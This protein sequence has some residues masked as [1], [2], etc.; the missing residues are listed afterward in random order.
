MQFF[1]DSPRLPLE[2]G[3]GLALLVLLVYLAALD[4]EN[5]GHFGEPT[6]MKIRELRLPN[7]LW[8]LAMCAV[9]M[10]KPTCAWYA[11]ARVLVYGMAVAQEMQY[12]R[13]PSMMVPWLAVE[14]M[15]PSPV[16]TLFRW[17]ARS[18][19]HEDAWMVAGV[20]YM[21][22][23]VAKDPIVGMTCAGIMVILAV[24]GWVLAWLRKRGSR[25]GHWIMNGKRTRKAK[26]GERH[27]GIIE[28]LV[29]LGVLAFIGMSAGNGVLSCY[30]V[31]TGIHPRKA[32]LEVDEYHHDPTLNIDH[33]SPERHSGWMPGVIEKKNV[34]VRKGEVL[35]LRLRLIGP[36]SLHCGW[37][38]YDNGNIRTKSHVV[39]NSTV[40]LGDEEKGLVQDDSVKDSATF[41]DTVEAMTEVDEGDTLFVLEAKATW[42]GGSYVGR[43]RKAKVMAVEGDQFYMQTE[44]TKHGDSGWPIF[45]KDNEGFQLVGNS[46]RINTFGRHSNQIEIVHQPEERGVVV[47]QSGHYQMIH[48]H[49]GSGKTR[50]RIPEIVR[51]STGRVY[52]LSPTTVAAKEA[53]DALNDLGI[54]NSLETTGG[55]ANNSRVKVMCHATYVKR[56]YHRGSSFM[57]SETATYIMDEYHARQGETWALAKWLKYKSTGKSRVYLMSATGPGHIMD[58]TN[59]DVDQILCK[60]ENQMLSHLIGGTTKDL[61]IVPGNVP[62]RA[63]KLRQK[64]AAAGDTREVIEMER[65]QRQNL[66]ACRRAERCVIVATNIVEMGANL[67]VENA[68]LTNQMYVPVQDEFGNVTLANRVPPVASMVQQKGRVG[69]RKPGKCYIVCRDQVEE[70]PTFFYKDESL[71]ED[72]AVYMKAMPASVGQYNVYG[73]DD[74]DEQEINERNQDYPTGAPLM[75]IVGSELPPRA[76]RECYESGATVYDLRAWKK[77]QVERVEERIKQPKTMPSAGIIV[78]VGF[79]WLL[80]GADAAVTIRDE[81][82]D[83]DIVDAVKR[84]GKVFGGLKDEIEDE[85]AE[86][87]SLFELPENVVV[88]IGLM[89]MITV[90]LIAVCY[91]SDRIMRM[92]SALNDWLTTYG[93]MFAILTAP[94]MAPETLSEMT[95]LQ[96][97]YVLIVT[98]PMAMLG[99]KKLFA[100]QHSNWHW[101]WMTLV[102][103]CIFTMS[104]GQF[105]V[106]MIRS[107]P[108]ARFYP[109]VREAAFAEIT[110]HSSVGFGLGTRVMLESLGRKKR[111]EGQHA[112]DKP[113]VRENERSWLGV[114]VSILATVEAVAHGLSLVL[115]GATL[116]RTMMR[117]TTQVVMATGGLVTVIG[118]VLGILVGIYVSRGRKYLGVQDVLATAGKVEERSLETNV[119]GAVAY[120]LD[121]VFLTGRWMMG[122]DIGTNIIG[123]AVVAAMMTGKLPAKLCHY[124]GGL[125]TQGVLENV[126]IPI[127]P[128]VVLVLMGPGLAATNPR[129]QGAIGSSG[130]FSKGWVAVKNIMNRMN[131]EEFAKFKFRGTVVVERPREICSK[132][133]YKTMYLRMSGGFRPFGHVIEDGGGKGGSTQE[134]VRQ[135]N[136]EKVTTLCFEK[137]GHMEHRLHEKR[138]EGYEKSHLVHGD[139]HVIGPAMEGDCYFNDIGESKPTIEE[140]TKYSRRHMEGVRTRLSK[141]RFK[142]ICVKELA[143]W[144]TERVAAFCKDFGLGWMTTPYTRNSSTEV[145]L[146]T[147][148]KD[149][150]TIDQRSREIL[151]RMGKYEPV[152]RIRGMTIPEEP[153]DHEY[154]QPDPVKDADGWDLPEPDY[155]DSKIT[156]GMK[157]GEIKLP[158]HRYRSVREV[159]YVENVGDTTSGTPMNQVIGRLIRL[160]KAAGCLGFWSLTD[161]SARAVFGVFNRKVDTP[162]K[163]EHKYAT[164]E[165]RIWKKVVENLKSRNPRARKLTYE[166]AL[167]RMANDAAPNFEGRCWKEDPGLKARVL[168]EEAAILSGKPTRGVCNTMG[169]RE[170]KDHQGF[171][172]KGSRQIAYYDIEVRIVE[173]MYFGMVCDQVSRRDVN[174]A[175]VGHI[176][177][178]DYFEMMYQEM[179]EKFGEAFQGNTSAMQDDIAGWDTRISNR[180]LREEIWGFQQLVD[181]SCSEGVRA[182]G[183]MYANHLLAVKRPDGKGVC[184]SIVMERKGRQSGTVVTYTANTLTNLK[185]TLTHLYVTTETTRTPEEFTDAWFRGETDWLLWISGDDKVVAG[186]TDPI[187]RAAEGCE[188]W[189]EAG[190]P[191]KNLGAEEASKVVE[192]M[193]DIEFCSHSPAYVTFRVETPGG[194][195]FVGKYMPNRD[196]GEIL[197]KILYSVGSFTSYDTMLAHAKLLRNYLIQYEFKRDI[198]RLVAALDACV[199]TDMVPMG[200]TAK[201]RQM[202]QPDWLREAKLGKVRQKVCSDSSMYPVGQVKHMLYITQDE[203]RLSGS[204]IHTDWRRRWVEDLPRAIE[205]IKSKAQDWEY[206]PYNQL[207]KVVKDSEKD[208][209]RSHVVCTGPRLQLGPLTELT[210]SKQHHASSKS[211]VYDNV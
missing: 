58:Q 156:Y 70:V 110:D 123:L 62:E 155:E 8:T 29:V 133:F 161:V 196:Q 199:P 44:K 68:F 168:A 76:A 75:R 11:M 101:I 25:H 174:P 184:M 65:S 78:G 46:G 19:T 158:K 122:L 15:L 169:K 77:L 52:I 9:H 90:L 104:H 7:V 113:I 137:T 112:S 28:G 136:V 147:G 193:E 151:E 27:G 4:A 23:T 144:D 150:A 146:C 59:Y 179:V 159:G 202:Y 175:S 10:V 31:P 16:G 154:T 95:V 50:N 63:K 13:R 198:A 69:R 210:T 190:F 86:K 118:A 55:N 204:Q 188:Y 82:M 88:Y 108:D 93:C 141:N 126:Y 74:M 207:E 200:K 152:T 91:F 35:D 41:G 142:Q 119:E 22:T 67:G 24:V 6:I 2:D 171:V 43:F 143:P 195:R 209:R 187:R 132:G 115:L 138:T 34:K 192:R 105:L 72:A 130:N 83:E 170:K 172:R 116:T 40:W 182:L 157:R 125:V 60:D 166:E 173:Q 148:G 102:T 38:V 205:E 162:T 131:Q 180:D 18:A 49:C 176:N 120:M 85:L 201:P 211:M 206:G 139:M 134:F 39:R 87:T 14:M 33:S 178:V 21:F 106:D 89:V 191:R 140:Q 181:E 53:H 135:K 12:A 100:Q 51:K 37:G 57:A 194:D 121:V 208:S 109:E 96:A 167:D 160:L 153:I 203:D 20:G 165:R 71:R 73:S 94:I 66:E 26:V 36:L 186:P 61:L 128:I 129:R 183:R 185:K 97:A 145:Y 42:F 92:L 81:D 32:H 54:K 197:A 5:G 127:L 80:G 64:M 163:E 45:K 164:T 177:P 103:F 98:L 117:G 149:I 79:S 30:A 84:Y 48:A 17:A 124:S 47:V 99:T 107:I 114:D 1:I 111:I 189:D 3:G 56:L